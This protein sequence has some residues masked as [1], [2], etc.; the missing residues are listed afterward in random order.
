MAATSDLDGVSRI[1]PCANCDPACEGAVRVRYEANDDPESW[2]YG[3]YA[4]ISRVRGFW[5]VA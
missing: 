1:A 4:A 5:N 2:G 3:R